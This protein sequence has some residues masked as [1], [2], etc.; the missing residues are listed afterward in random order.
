MNGT[1]YSGS[2]RVFPGK[3]PMSDW[4]MRCVSGIWAARIEG[5]FSGYF[6]AAVSIVICSSTSFF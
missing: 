6:S 1:N 4:C 3:D 2:A 5:R